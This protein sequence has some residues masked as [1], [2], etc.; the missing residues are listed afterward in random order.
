MI[1]RISKGMAFAK[2]RAGEAQVTC[3]K[4]R[5]GNFVT[6]DVVMTLV[7][8]P[9]PARGG[10]GVSINL[11]RSSGDDWAPTRHMMEVSSYLEREGTPQSTG[12][13]KR[14]VKGKSETLTTAV[15]ILLESGYVT[16]ALGSRSANMYSHVKPFRMGDHFTVPDDLSGDDDTGA[17]C[18]HLWHEGQPCN[19]DWCHARHRGRCNAMVD[20]GYV[21]DADGEVI[22]EPS[23]ITIPRDEELR[24]IAERGGHSEEQ[25]TGEERCDD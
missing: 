8:N 14:N 9:E 4:D 3:T 5:H 12:A 20:E 25:R 7:V 17:G 15:R 6:G 18:V 22:S 1:Q 2:G 11:A 13:I 10:A 21:L 24:I 19:L 16:A 23:A